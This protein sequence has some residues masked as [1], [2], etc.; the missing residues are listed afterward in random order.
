M[1]STP[2]AQVLADIS[3]FIGKHPTPQRCI[4]AGQML[5]KAEAETIINSS[6]KINLTDT[7]KEQYICGIAQMVS[8]GTID[9]VVKKAAEDAY[10]NAHNVFMEFMQA[11]FAL[12]LFDQWHRT[13]F[14]YQMIPIVRKTEEFEQQSKEIQAQIEE[15]RSSFIHLIAEARGSAGLN[16]VLSKVEETP[17]EDPVRKFGPDVNLGLPILSLAFSLYG[18]LAAFLTIG[19]LSSLGTAAALN[20]SLAVSCAVA[21]PS[22]KL[23]VSMTQASATPTLNDTAAQFLDAFRKNLDGVGQYWLNSILDAREIEDWLHSGALMAVRLHIR[24]Q[25]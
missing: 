3:G 23:Q 7:E 5:S 9:D 10:Q 25:A 14:A 12:F 11:S 15:L 20:A 17:H 19:G 2:I 1:S 4:G 18:P 22:E 16:F 21:Q 13:Q 6:N 24:R 8:S